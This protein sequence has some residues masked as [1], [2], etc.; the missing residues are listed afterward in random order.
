[1]ILRVR[2]FGTVRASDFDA[3]H[4]RRDGVLNSTLLGWIGE[5]AECQF[6]IKYIQRLDKSRQKEKYN[7]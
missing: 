6:A 2:Y 4:W 7:P 3:D 5:N 1:M